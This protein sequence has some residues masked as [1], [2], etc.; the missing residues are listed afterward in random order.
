MNKKW[1]DMSAEEKI[2]ELARHINAIALRLDQV[3]QKLKGMDDKVEKEKKLAP[4]PQ[5]FG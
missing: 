5:G 4:D 2:E 3:E 1:Q